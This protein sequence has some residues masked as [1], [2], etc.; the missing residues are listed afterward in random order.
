MSHDHLSEQ[1][2]RA[3]DA[4]LSPPDDTHPCGGHGC[5][6]TALPGAE[7]CDDCEARYVAAGEHEPAC[8]CG[9][10]VWWSATNEVLYGA[11]N[12]NDCTDGGSL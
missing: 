6:A 3:E 1:C 4:Y 12:D 11:E 7:L 2:R 10:C 5:D 8:R 9:E